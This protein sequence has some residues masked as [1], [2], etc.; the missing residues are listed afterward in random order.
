[1]KGREIARMVEED[2]WIFVRQKGSHRHYKH[3]AK[4]GIV[5][6]AGRPGADLAKG[7][8]AAILRQAGIKLE[9]KDQK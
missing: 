9:E 2:G 3:P 4:S 5:T 7:T 8:V 1:V 6:I